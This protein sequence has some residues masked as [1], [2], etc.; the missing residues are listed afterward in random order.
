[1]TSKKL[2]PF[3]TVVGIGNNRKRLFT[4]LGHLTQKGFIIP[5]M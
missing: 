5:K 4:A 2:C 3:G 1:M